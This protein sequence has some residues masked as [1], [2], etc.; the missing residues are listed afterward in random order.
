VTGLTNWRRLRKRTRE[1]ING[2]REALHNLGPSHRRTLEQGTLS[3][4]A[5]NRQLDALERLLHAWGKAHERQI[6]RDLITADRDA[7]EWLEK[8]PDTEV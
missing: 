3:V 1:E 2:F 5:L 6:R 8:Y 4:H 7:R